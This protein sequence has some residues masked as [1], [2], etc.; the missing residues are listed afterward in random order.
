MIDIDKIKKKEQVRI[1]F[2]NQENEKLRLA[3]LKKAEK[4]LQK[5]FEH[6]N[7]KVYLFGSITQPF[8]F[9]KLSDIDIAV[10]NCNISR[11]DLFIELEQLFDKKI[12]LIILEKCTFRDDILKNGIIVK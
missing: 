9:S 6:S 1:I 7:T 4:I 10:E 12:D 8:M 2:Q 11:I 5:Y 3:E